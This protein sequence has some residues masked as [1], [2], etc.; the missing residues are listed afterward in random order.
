MSKTILDV[1]KGCDNFVSNDESPSQPETL[2]QCY[3]FRVNGC[4]AILGYILPE[5]VEK[6][7]WSGWWSIDHHR[8]TVTLATPATAPADM[9]S[10]VVEET[11]KN[12]RKLA[13]ISM[14]ESWRDEAFPIYGPGGETLL[15]IERCASALFGIVT[16]GVQL[17][18]YVW[19]EQGLRLWIGKRS[20]RKQTYPGM[21]DT[22]AAGGLVAG[23]LPIEALI[24]E[25][26]E[27]ASFPEEMVR[28]NV[29]PM[30]NLTYFHVR[31]SK[32]GGEIGLF[33]PE[34]EYTYKLE[35]DPGTAPE[36]RDSEVEGFSLYTIEEVLCALKEGLF[37]PN[38]AVVIVDFLISHGILRAD[39]EPGYAEI[40]SHL[41]RE[42]EL[43]LLILPSK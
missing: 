21:L 36:P 11:L 19:D 26:Q 34:V 1:V 23:K 40:L 8:R 17:V 25:A 20:E 13:V 33:Q 16:Y 22:T 7:Q 5:V 31:G 4:C 41:H 37:K 27:E 18:C 30:S 3:T 9:R 32:A 6:V 35:L 14:L 38:S 24:C 2:G 29:I 15:E 42:L 43:P 39:N 28:R 12:T 10:R